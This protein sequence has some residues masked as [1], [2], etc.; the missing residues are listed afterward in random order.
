MDSIEKNGLT[1]SL[2]T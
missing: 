2:Q 1:P